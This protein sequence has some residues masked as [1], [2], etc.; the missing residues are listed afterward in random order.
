MT[1]EEWLPGSGP[2]PSAARRLIVLPHAGSGAAAWLRWHCRLPDDVELRVA[3]LP[4][5]ENRLAEPPLT[6]A[7]VVVT[8]L[9][10][11]LRALP[12]LPFVVLGHSLGALLGV[13][14]CR[15]FPGEARALVVSGQVAPDVASTQSDLVC[16]PDAE[17][18]AAV[19]GRWDAIPA[20]ILS[21]SE[22]LS[23]FMPALRADLTLLD[24][25]RV[26]AEPP[27][28]VPIHILAGLDDALD[29]DGLRRWRNYTRRPTQLIRH[30]GGHMAVLR[31]PT[32]TDQAISV[33]LRRL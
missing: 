13:E 10:A 25:C 1:P 28:D 9:A 17:L 18:A 32:V 24:S 23:I 29:E 31:D 8:A 27:L 21:N 12:P 22:F 3:R 16:L 20:A 33:C 26:A 14:L 5:R 30:F 6:S 11:A 19:N 4:G 2:V 15:A 7:P